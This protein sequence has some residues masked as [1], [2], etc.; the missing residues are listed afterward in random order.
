M[1][2]D[3]YKEIIKLLK[4]ETIGGWVFRLFKTKR[5]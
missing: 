2:E 3:R 5:R 1:K 4:Y